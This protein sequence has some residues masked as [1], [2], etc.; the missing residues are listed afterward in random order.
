MATFIPNVQD[1]LPDVKMF[2][3]DFG[4]ID[5][6][7]KRKEAQYEEGFA[8]LNNQYNLINR[9]VTNPYNAKTRDE[10]LKTAKTNLK[11]LSAMD[12]SD[13]S[14]VSM[15]GQVFKPFYDNKF[16]I[17]DQALTSYWKDQEGIA[18]SLRI[19][20]GGKYFSIDN[21]KYIQMQKAEFSKADPS[22]V[23]EYMANK[24]GYTPYYDYSEEMKQALKD[25]KPS[26]TK[27]ISQ[28][29]MYI[30][31]TE[32][33]SYN[34]IELQKYLNATLSDKAKQ[35]MRIEGTVRLGNDTN[36]LMNA[37]MQSEGTKIPDITKMI[38]DIDA[39]LKVETDPAVITQL[40]QNKEY[41]NDQR[42]EIGNNVKSIRGGDMSF[43]KK[44]AEAL[45]FKPYM[46]GI[47]DKYALGAAHEVKF[48]TIGFDDVQMM[49]YREN[50]ADAR[51]ERSLAH[52]DKQKAEDRQWEL[53]KLKLGKLGDETMYPTGPLDLKAEDLT[54]GGAQ[55]ELV[56][57]KANFQNDLLALTTYVANMKHMSVA[58][59]KGATGAA[60]INAYIK[61]N[62]NDKV[63]Q[64]YNTKMALLQEA[65]ESVAA[66]N[67]KALVSTRNILGD[68]GFVKF[69]NYKNAL[70][71]NGG[72]QALAIKASGVTP[73]IIEKATTQINNF[74]K[75]DNT[76][77]AQGIPGFMYGEDTDIY[78]KLKGWAANGIDA[79]L[80]SGIRLYPSLKNA[81]DLAVAVRIQGP[82]AIESLND[83]KTQ[84]GIL[85]RYKSIYNGASVKW[86]A[87]TNSVIIKGL[88]KEFVDRFDP[89]RNIPP[90]D[91]KRL[92]RL[93]DW[94]L[95]PNNSYN[96]TLVRQ[97]GGSGTGAGDGKNRVLTIQ[98]L[99][100][101][102][103]GAAPIYSIFI[104]NK[105]VEGNSYSSIYDAVA[106]GDF[107]IKNNKT[108]DLDAS[109]KQ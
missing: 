77:V 40:K 9:D 55:K 2:T 42:T 21:L 7:M 76:L 38:D 32:N 19:K 27:L 50:A 69:V 17:G 24:R 102:G 35:Q 72:N 98:K 100:P 43:L 97:D 12:L 80:I 4:F 57:A 39:K 62:P 67:N 46:S 85:D 14:N 52:S 3:P 5:K 37:Y 94:P 92:G 108:S 58:D 70:A 15:A 6:M 104:D 31:T 91:R 73:A 99:Q 8:Q 81:N 107:I 74:L 30:K 64:S 26:H 18:D 16:V 53:Y 45:A 75:P 93:L 83:P 60:F 86:N 84:A 78:K 109:L 106:N 105:A 44:N 33:E 79:S 88:N 54:V 10:F 63:V 82:K 89:A 71:K 49:Y 28:K 20:D 66:I 59:L 87:A 13:P 36:F 103:E 95:G 101:P 90:A 51:Q 65:Q 34:A 1:V 41:Y 68:D 22:S 48:E 23:G 56:D 25:F 61:A 29:G 47:V 96:T 11:D